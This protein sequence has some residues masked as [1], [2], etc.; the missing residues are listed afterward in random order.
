M[1]EKDLTDLGAASARILYVEDDFDSGELVRFLLS[2][3]NDNYDV[4]VV[5]TYAEA[6]KVIGEKPFNLYIIDYCL[7]SKSGIQLC[8][9]IRETDQDTPILFFSA[10]GW[11]KDRERARKAGATDYLVKPADLELLTKRVNQLLF[12]WAL[13]K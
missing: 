6:V 10:I 4:K 11:E 9:H 12:E 8:R 3:E 7:P 13:A 2:R 1:E 5:A